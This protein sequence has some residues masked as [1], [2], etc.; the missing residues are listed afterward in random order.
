MS[1]EFSL[2][3]VIVPSVSTR[4]R[5]IATELPVPESLP[6]LY[7]LRTCEP[8]SMRGQPPVV[9]DRASGSQVYD[10]YGNCW[11]DWSSGVLVAN[12]GHSATAVRDAIVRETNRG[13][14][15]SY[16]FPNAARAELVQTLTMLAPAGLDKV[17]L[18]STGAEAVEAA[19]KLARTW[20]RSAGGP[21]KRAIVSFEGAFHGR[22]MGAQMAG[23][24]PALKEWIGALDPDMVQVPFPGALRTQD[25]TFAAFTSGL[26]SAGVA[27]DRVCAVLTETF[28]GG[29]ASF[30][31]VEYAQELRRWCTAHGALL[32]MDEIQA[33][34]G[35]T[36]KRFGFEHYGIVPD[37]FCL[38]KGITSSLPLSAVVGRTEIMDQYAPNEMTSTHSGNPIC[39]AAA[40]ASLRTIEENGLTGH[41]AR[42]G[43]R[44]HAGLARIAARRP[45]RIAAVHGKGLVAGLHIVKPGGLDP[46]G[47]TAFRVV[48][49][50][51]Q[52]GLLLFAPVGTGYAT[53][54]IAPPLPIEPDAVD[55]GLEVL[56]EA[57][58]AATQGR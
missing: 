23:G 30:M 26:D 7:A 57:M 38:G 21:S 53:V 41:A 22:T 47:D 20:G 54:K 27:P 18:L 10:A 6:I 8:R 15:H 32:I 12:A 17:F 13:L 37:L 48:E 28:Q 58:A 42:M 4:H 31:P 44:L 3:P 51:F 14:L 9:W 50:A 24:S 52:R 1:R 39:C 40:L 36:G 25:R 16:C 56:E 46:D 55:E 19:L 33:A 49:G 11:L 43:E 2:D 29:G 5:R 45:D 34:F 35:R